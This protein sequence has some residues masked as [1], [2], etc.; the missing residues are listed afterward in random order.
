MPP[1][2]QYEVTLDSLEKL[3]QINPQ[4][5]GYCHFGAVT[6]VEDSMVMLQDQKELI[7]TCRERIRQLYEEYQSTRQVVS[8]FIRETYAIRTDYPPGNKIIENIILAV[9][10]GML[11]ELGYKEP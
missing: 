3:I 2:F 11:I 7:G 8:E 6:T 1:S 4:N 10:Y 5:I 9:V